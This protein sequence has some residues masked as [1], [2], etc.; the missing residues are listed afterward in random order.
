MR[1]IETALIYLVPF[2]AIGLVGRLL[3]PRWMARHGA[4][5]SDMDARAGAK[6]WRRVFPVG[7]SRREE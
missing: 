3:I 5:P 1:A 6:R 7:M 4:E 2:L